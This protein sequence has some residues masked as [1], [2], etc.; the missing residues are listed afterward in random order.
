MSDFDPIDV[1]F[2]INDEEVS[3]DAKKVRDEL[4]G[5]VRDIE[6]TTAR[7][8]RQITNT[9]KGSTVEIQKNTTALT[10]QRRQYDGLGNSIAQI[11]RELPAFTFSAQTGFLAISNNLPIL[12]DEIGRLK[13]Q[14]EELVASGQKSRSVFGQVAKSFLSWN[15]VL[16]VGV[17]LLTIYGPQIIDF[18]GNLFR[19]KSAIDDNTASLEA[20]NQAYESSSYQKAVRGVVE[21]RAAFAGAGEDIER[22]S[23]AL[24]LYNETLG[25]A[26]GTANNYNAAEKIFRDKSDAYVRALLFRAAATEAVNEASKELTRITKEQDEVQRDID[27][28]GGTSSATSQFA[29]TNLR[30]ERSELQR[31]ANEVESL[32]NRIINRLNQRA[33][34]LAKAFKLDFDDDDDGADKLISER[35]KLLDK[36]EALDNEFAKKRLEDDDAEVK[37]VQDKFDKVRKLVEAF[38]ADPTTRATARIDLEAFEELEQRALSDLDFSQD[39]RKLKEELDQQRAIFEDFEEYKKNFGLEKAKERYAE[40]LKEFESFGEFI[41]QLYEANQPTFEAFINGSATAVQNER[42]NLIIDEAEKQKR[43]QDQLYTD[44]LASLQSYEDRRTLLLEQYQERRALLLANGNATAVRELDSIFNEELNNLDESFAKGTDEYKALIRGVENLSDAAALTVI[45]NARKMVQALIDAGRLS[46]ESAADINGKIDALENNVNTR[47][48]QRFTAVAQGISEVSNALLPLSDNLREVDEDLANS[49]ETLAQLGQVAV[50]VTSSIAG[51]AAGGP[52]GIA[53]GIA[54]AISALGNLIGLTKNQT[55]ASEESQQRVLDFQ[56]DIEDGEIRLNK[57]LRER[58]LER[59]KELDLTLRSLTAQREA[60]RISQQQVQTDQERIFNLLQQEQFV[61]G[62]DDFFFDI[63]VPELDDL[64]GKTFEEIEALFENGQ[65]TERAAELFEQLRALRNEGEDIDG[66]LRDL[67]IQQQQLFTG[68]TS[69]AIS[70]SIIEGL[71]NGY[72]SFEDFAGDIEKVLQGAILNSIKFQLLEEPLQRLFEQFAGFAESDGELTQAEADAVRAAYE[73]Q[74]QDAIDR[75]N[76]L[77]DVLDLDA[78]DG[79]NESGLQGAIRRE[80]TEET[81]SELTGLFRG[82]FD[83]TKRHF[84]LAEQ[85]FILEKE[86]RASTIQMVQIQ[87]AIEQN[88]RLMADTLTV[89]VQELVSIRKNTKQGQSG[90]DQGLGG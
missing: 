39:T 18:I 82:Q 90:R 89:A 28:R 37:A 58:N 3:R 83:I 53:A 74:V 51:F 4:Q 68:T 14:N 38:N 62:F 12:A 80:L 70:D 27:E 23:D 84:Q 40:E 52:A 73:Q 65:L 8:N 49:I 88:T 69:S 21:V 55:D 1:A 20:L 34:D 56:N 24:K 75:Y 32:Y 61:S 57:L 76:Q 16:S 36:I 60:L 43:I 35:Q 54:G 81:A 42:A 5:T 15:T 79:A 10:T 30:Q 22:K 59:A 66:L 86:N 64:L 48:A 71:R 2:L 11:T 33:D 26:L 47:S 50:D 67:E 72:D 78:L 29:T 13:V 63:K 41:Q 77:S 7:A 25:D 85:Q 17:T 31:E 9:F 6:T 44:L 19:S 87:V 46:E 45:E